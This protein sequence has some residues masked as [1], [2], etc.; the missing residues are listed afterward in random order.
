M[1][2]DARIE[3][4][5]INNASHKLCYMCE[6]KTRR[7]KFAVIEN[8]RTDLDEFIRAPKN[9]L[10]RRYKAN[11]GVSKISPRFGLLTFLERKSQ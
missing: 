6:K 9:K 1:R 11:K 5:E 7:E 8:E 2:D 10:S 3:E 4:N